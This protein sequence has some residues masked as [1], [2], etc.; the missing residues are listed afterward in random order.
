[1]A[2]AEHT[3]ESAS[4]MRSKDFHTDPAT[5]ADLLCMHNLY[6][7][8][9]F[10]CYLYEA[11]SWW[12]TLRLRR[13]DATDAYEQCITKVGMLRDRNCQYNRL[14]ALFLSGCTR[15]I[16]LSDHYSLMTRD[17]AV[18]R[19]LEYIFVHPGKVLY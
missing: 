7:K 6:L 1:M 9:S 4:C 10:P 19:D 18:Y 15:T 5:S 12:E 8:C 14:T 2:V 3:F 11:G 17:C 13:T 16:S